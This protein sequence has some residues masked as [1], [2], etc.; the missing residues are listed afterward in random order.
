MIESINEFSTAII[1]L[2]TIIYTTGTLLLWIANRRTVQLLSKEVSHQI[3]AGYSDA[4]H[5]T[6][7]AHRDLFIPIITNDK[8]L[9]TLASSLRLEVED[10]RQNFIASMFINHTLRIFLDYKHNIALEEND[11]GFELDARDLFSI[12]F[13]KK[14]LE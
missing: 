14:T 1:A 9:E 4:H 7:N 2:C 5:N 6:L 10:I 13:V 3:S 11:K 12:D 8:L